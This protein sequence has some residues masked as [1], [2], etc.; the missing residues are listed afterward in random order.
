MRR[1]FIFTAVKE[2]DEMDWWK[3]LEIEYLI[4]DMVLFLGGDIRYVQKTQIWIITDQIDVEFVK[5]ESMFVRLAVTSPCH[6][7]VLFVY[8]CVSHVQIS[9]QFWS[10]GPCFASSRLSRP[11]Y[12][13]VQL[14]ECGTTL[15]EKKGRTRLLEC[16]TLTFWNIQDHPKQKSHSPERK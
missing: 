7:W 6:T 4:F 13:P 14:W 8:T 11:F 9:D 2:M 5:P 15:L 12:M 16:C 1:A 10:Y 3:M